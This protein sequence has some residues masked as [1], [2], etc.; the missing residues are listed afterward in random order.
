MGKLTAL[1]SVVVGVIALGS[2]PA[3]NEDDPAPEPSQGVSMN[4]CRADA[5]AGV[6]ASAGEPSN[7]DP[8][9]M[10]ALRMIEQGRRVFRDETFGDEAFWGDALKLHRAVGGE[11][12]A[13][14]GVGPGLTPEAALALGLKVDSEA[15]PASVITALQRGEVDLESADT[16][17]VLLQANAV[18]GVK[19][20]FDG[21]QM[22]SMGIQCALCHSTVDDSLA[23][24]IGKRLDGWANRDL[25]VGKIVALAPD[26][27]PIADVLS[28]A[29]TEVTVETVK[30]V[31]ESWGPGKYD[32]ELL[33]DGKAFQDAAMTRS[34][35]T[36]LPPAF[37][38]AGVNMHTWTGFGSVTYWNA[39]VANTQMHGQG[40]FYD[41][42]LQDAEQFPVAAANGLGNVRPATDLVTDK[43]AALQFYQLALEPPKPPAGSFDAAAA[44]RGKALFGDK[45]QCATCHVPPLYTE[46]GFNMHTPAE[47]GIDDFQ[48]SR[49]PE[50]MYRTAPLRGLFSHQKGGFYHD[51]RF[52]TLAEVVDHYDANLPAPLGPLDLTASEKTDLVEF[53]KSL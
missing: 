36:L 6:D 52:A 24:G 41:P 12:N 17:I 35:A 34:A 30:A 16:T 23:A 20:I 26:L 9:A 40:T 33:L 42:R 3:C 53:L 44:E 49:S 13:E 39:F 21:D 8:V 28:K 4:E 22:T 31:L 45:A 15:L 5:A 37:G 51:G 18:V 50:G 46:P 27:Q 32:A 19:A 29:G 38:M 7:G 48:A 25:D 1:L 14:N 10:A 43:L 11:A 47:I 2:L